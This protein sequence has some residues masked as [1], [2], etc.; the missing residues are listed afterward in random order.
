MLLSLTDNLRGDFDSN[1]AWKS[2]T[3]INF[4]VKKSDI[5]I[6]RCIIYLIRK[7]MKYN[8]LFIRDF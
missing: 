7:L 6:T 4:S 5:D 2:V 1:V 3:E 8:L